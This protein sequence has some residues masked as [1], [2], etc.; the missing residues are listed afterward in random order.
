MKP[1]RTML[2]LLFAGFSSMAFGQV[3]TI[4]L[5]AEKLELKD[6]DTIISRSENLTTGEL[7]YLSGGLLVVIRYEDG[8]RTQETVYFNN[9]AEK[10]VYRFKN[11]KKHG[12]FHESNMAGHPKASGYYASGIE[13]SLW[14]YYYF[15]GVKECEGT[16][17]AD[18]SRLI[19]DFSMAKSI[20]NTEPPFDVSDI[21]LSFRKHAPPHGEWYFY[22][23]KGILI[24]TLMFEYGLLKGIRL[25]EEEGNALDFKSR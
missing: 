7:R 24:K 14:T 6:T 20:T 18:T 16:Y 10:S 2:H 11:G 9:G 12:Y 3:N 22:D 23:R 17:V 8:Y 4:L 13:D 21:T 15:N 1:S 25:A 5:S 19:T